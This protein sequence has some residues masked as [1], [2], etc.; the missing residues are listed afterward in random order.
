MP[1][2]AAAIDEVAARLLVAERPV[3][4]VNGNT[5]ALAC[6]ELLQIADSLGCPLKSIFTIELRN[7]WLVFL[8][9]LGARATAI[10]FESC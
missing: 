8:N 5:V 3:I 9:E 4:S 1:G 6:D 7:E 2:A 10:R